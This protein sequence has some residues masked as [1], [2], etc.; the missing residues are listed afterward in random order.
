M[1]MVDDSMMDV[2]LTLRAIKD[3]GLADNCEMAA[4]GAEAY[5]LL[6][7]TTFDLLLLDIKNVSLHITNFLFVA[8]EMRVII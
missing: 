8:C 3:C 4:D 6:G 2:L 1:L 5:A 7:R